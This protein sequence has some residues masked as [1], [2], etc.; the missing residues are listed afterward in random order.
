MAEFFDAI[1][2]RQRAFMAGQAVFFVATAAADGRISL[3]PKGHD[4]FRVLGD[5]LV[6]YVDAGD[7]DE[8]PAQRTSDGRITLMF[9]ALDRP[10]LILRLY[11]R[12][13]TVLPQD[14]EWDMAARSF[15]GLPGA[16]RIVLVHVERV[17]EA[18]DAA[19]TPAGAEPAEVLAA[20]PAVAAERPWVPAV[21]QHWLD[22]IGPEG[23]FDSSD[24]EDA[25]ILHLFG[26]L[27]HVQ[28]DKPREQAHDG[29]GGGDNAGPVAEIEKMPVAQ[30]ETVSRMEAVENAVGNIKEPGA[31]KKNEERAGG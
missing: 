22:E 23:W 2:D 24:E 1:T 11:G 9:C 27:W 30:P 21:L 14:D 13:R 17:E 26:P 25:R 12:G 31:E 3:S 6:G 8:T 15:N 19:L 16:R 28:Q 20:P 7:G 4:S 29:N 18:R 10:A 5:N